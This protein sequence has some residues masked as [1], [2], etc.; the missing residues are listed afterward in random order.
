MTGKTTFL[1]GSFSF[2]VPLSV[3]CTRP[4][5][6]FS[7]PTLYLTVFFFCLS[8]KKKWVTAE[9]KMGELARQLE[10]SRDDQMRSEDLLAAETRKQRVLQ[11][12]LQ[13]E[14]SSRGGGG[15]GGGVAGGWTSSRT[16]AVSA[17]I[18]GTGGG[19]GGMT[20]HLDIVATIN[21]NQSLINELT[22]RRVENGRLRKDNAQLLLHAKDVGADSKLLRAQV[23]TSVH[24]RAELLRKLNATKEE[25]GVWKQQLQNTAETMIRRHQYER[26]SAEEARW[27][28]LEELDINNESPSR[29]SYRSKSARGVRNIPVEGWA[30]GRGFGKYGRA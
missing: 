17:P 7:V 1:S 25:A 28:R 27:E 16:R 6:C 5:F 19:V 30:S 26:A 11:Q 13:K 24:D 22:E 4:S 29:R 9:A 20:G 3:T 14:L 23:T 15:A 10:Q 18:R 12:A 21:R 8:Y 2:S